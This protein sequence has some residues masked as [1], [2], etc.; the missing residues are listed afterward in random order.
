[1]ATQHKVDF[2]GVEYS[3]LCAEGEH[4]VTIKSF[5]EQT[6]KS[7]GNQMFVGK[8]TIKSGRDRGITIMENFPIT[9]KAL[10]KLKALFDAIGIPTEGVTNFTEKRLVGKT[11]IVEVFH[12]EY[13]K[14][15][16]PKI[17]AFKKLTAQDIEP[18]E[19]EDDEDDDEP[20]KAAAKKNAKK[21]EA[22]RYNEDDD[23]DEEPEPMPSQRAKKKPAPP[24]VEDDDDEDW[25]EEETPPPKK[26]K[27]TAAP[28]P[29]AKKKPKPAPKVPDDDDDDEDWEEA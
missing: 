6:A 23:G 1:M 27:T 25:E 2:T 7:S 17:S 16:R 15:L 18:P 19:D 3:A 20:P 28:P 4:I 22:Q 14:Q 9:E 8:F 11:L 26:K 24:P 5:K 10:W 29:S 21:R 13:Q 12:D